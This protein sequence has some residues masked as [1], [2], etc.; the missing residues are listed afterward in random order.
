MNPIRFSILAVAAVMAAV[1]VAPPAGAAD[2]A[3]GAKL[4]QRWCAACHVVQNGQ[5]AAS[6]DAPPFDEM[7]RRPGFT[8]NGLATFLITTH[9][10]M[11]DMN[12]SRDEAA[13][14]AAY[15]GTQK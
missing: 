12:L 15:V 10:K 2:A 9:K 8:E 13:D 5:R 1:I 14:I 3:N 6:A 4:A 11:P 7:A